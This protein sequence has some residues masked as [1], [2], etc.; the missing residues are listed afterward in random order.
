MGQP[1]AVAFGVAG[2]LWLLLCVLPG[3]LAVSALDPRRSAL[4][5]LAIAPL[6]SLGVGFAVAAWL[7]ALHVPGSAWYAPASLGVVAVGS[8]I[9]IARRPRA[10]SW[11]RA[12]TPG[13]R[14]TWAVIGVALAIPLLLW[15]VAIT[16]SEPGWA[17]VV[18]SSDGTTHGI[19][20]TDILRGGSIY[21]PLL[22][23][24]DLAVAG[25]PGPVGPAGLP[26]V[27]YPLALHV[28]AAPIAAVT[29]VPSALLVPLTVMASAWLV[30]GAVAL[31]RRFGSPRQALAAGLA[32]SC[33]APMV[34]FWHVYWGPAPMMLAVALVPAAT[35]A[36]LDV[37]PGRG[38]IVPTLAVAG[39]F[40]LHVTE[41]LVVIGLAGVH[42]L[43]VR[44][45]AGWWRTTA[46][47]TGC[48][49]AALVVAAP[50]TAYLVFAHGA[51]RP[52]DAS[53]RLEA[54]PALFV[55]LLR[56]VVVLTESHGALLVAVLAAGVTM[57]ILTVVGA[58]SAWVHP[59][60]RSLVVVTLVCLGIGVLA[61]VGA[62]PI[63]TSP[64]YTN[65]DRVIGQA[66][67]LV[68]SLIGIGLVVVAQRLRREPVAVR[69]AGLVGA[70]L[71]VAVMAVQAVGAAATGLTGFSVVTAADRDAFVW[72]AEH[73]APGQRVLNDDTDGSAW[74][75]ESS[76]GTVFPLFG[77][78]PGEGFQSH[79]EYADRLHLLDTVQDIATNA[80]TRAE[81][82]RWNV[83]Y[84]M[85]GERTVKNGPRFLDAEA[86]ATAEGL[87]EVFSSGGAKVYEI[88]AR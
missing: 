84:V 66:A 39:L 32:A 41:L 56:P 57:V 42:Q 43:C 64:W 68:P 40:S 25:D 65:G 61:Y 6:V 44:R 55:A 87:R 59:L 1:S 60:G 12:W 85:V 2:L 3:F 50:L 88:V 75:Y 5:R 15:T 33:L 37:R 76:A 36:L 21:P 24:A 71:I 73:A 86:L 28:L 70:A 20:L 23:R 30:L 34:P 69:A 54:V 9:V 81:A 22:G 10:V 63:L 8:A 11:R 13:R 62:V 79:D 74:M 4:D 16:I 49:L 38:L 83:K 53:P 48:G 18:P 72:L 35:I 80:Q 14:R 51:A 77:G 31:T 67:A 7:G 45:D 58:R 19:V 17:T 52:Q 82:V 26:V 47:M 46:R 78:R 29:T 27:T